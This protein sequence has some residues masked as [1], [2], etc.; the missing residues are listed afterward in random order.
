MVNKKILVT[1]GSGYVGSLLVPKLLGKDYKVRVLDNLKYRQT[2]SLPYFINRGFEFVRGDVRDKATIK[3]SLDGVD[4]V[5][6]L[7]IIVGAPACARDLH[8]RQASAT[9]TACR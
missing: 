6:H 1:G 9:S 8:W 5:I 7:A 3:E 2:S 4:T